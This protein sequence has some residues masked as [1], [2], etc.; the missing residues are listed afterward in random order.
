MLKKTADGSFED[1]SGRVIFFSMER[2]MRDIVEGDC[3]FIC[4]AN[5]SQV[6][7]NNEHVLPRWLLKRYALFDQTIGLPNG[8]KFK[9]SEY[10]VSCCQ[11]CNSR[12]GEV[13]EQPVRDIIAGGCESVVTHVKER[14][15]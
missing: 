14:G 9:Y 4:G 13:I 15:W 3:C 8:L 1:G 5:P 12:M 2:F 11:S 7:F 6:P 10:K